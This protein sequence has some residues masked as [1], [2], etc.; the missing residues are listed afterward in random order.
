M[1]APTQANER[2]GEWQAAVAEK[3]RRRADDGLARMSRHGMLTLLLL[4]LLTQFTWFYIVA[5]PAFTFFVFWLAYQ[6]GD[7]K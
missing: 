5:N 3:V 1:A 6:Y 7:V 4:V 2:L